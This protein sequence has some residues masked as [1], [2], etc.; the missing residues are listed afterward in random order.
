MTVERS[1]GDTAVAYDPECGSLTVSGDGATLASGSVRVAVGGVEV[2]ATAETT[3]REDGDV[4]RVTHEQALATTVTLAPADG[5]VDVTVAVENGTEDPVGLDALSPL[6]D[7]TTPFDR[8]DRVFEHGY[9]SWTPTATRTLGDAFPAEPAHNRPQMLDLDAAFLDADAPEDARTSHYLTALAGDPGSL[10]LAFLEHDAYLSRFDVE[11]GDET[12]LTAVCPG[13]GVGLAPGETRRSATLRVDATRSVPDALAA[14]ASAVGDRMNALVPERS[15]T[16]WCTWYHYFTGVTADDVR[17]NL[18]ALEDWSVPVDV[19]QLD[20]GYE[21]AFGDWR[22]L[23][24]GFEDMRAL[25]DDVADAGYRPGLWLAPFYVQADSDLADE[26]PEWLVVDAEGDPV[27]AGERHGPM[28]GLDTTHPD[29]L[30]WLADTFETVVDD[31]GFSY[32]K[33]DFLYAA[34]LPGE[35]HEDV[36]RAEAYRRGLSTIR[37]AVGDDAFVLGCG[38]PQFP[39]VGLVDAMRVGPDTAPHWRDPDGLASQPAHENA[40]R[41]VLNRQFLHRRLWANDPDCQLVRETTDLSDAER[42][43]FAAVV[44]LSGGANVFSDALEEIGAGGRSLLERTLPPVETGRVEGVGRREFPDRMVTERASDDALALAA[45][46][47]TDEPRAVTVD[48]AESLVADAEGVADSGDAGVRCWDALA[49][50][51]VDAPVERDLQPHDVAVL[52]CAPARS[53]PH[54]V[55]ARHLANAADQVVDATWDEDAGTLTV[56]L[57]AGRAMELVAAVPDG[58]TL[59]DDGD[60]PATSPETVGTTRFL[61]EPGRTTVAFERRDPA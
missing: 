17:E 35:R 9:Q 33:L 45:F 47:W 29:A 53:R 36:T 34:A 51:L 3:V 4:V 52:H 49:G 15:P 22:T 6:R 23:A 59:A 13:D 44:A 58:W 7:A 38:A 27:D 25:R 48:P 32:L 40:V 5:A 39:S 10:A 56:D 14:S 21:T 16:G 2:P 54:L 28:Y 1:A 50:E 60:A 20:D 42:R 19:V 12:D 37:E 55:G 57:D 43:A 46:N 18:D 41:N 26:H 30:D 31:W 8:D 61:A 24:D 11:P